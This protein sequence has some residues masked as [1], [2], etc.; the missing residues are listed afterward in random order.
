MVQSS[1]VLQKRPRKPEEQVAPGLTKMKKKS[2]RHAIPYGVAS[3]KFALKTECPVAESGP[4][5]SHLLEMIYSNDPVVA[6]DF[7]SH[8][9]SNV[10]H[11]GFDV[12][13]R[14]TYRPGQ[15]PNIALLQFAPLQHHKTS[16]PVLLYAMY[17][18]E[19]HIP[20]CLQAIIKD[21]GIQKYGIG[22]KGDIRHL[23]YMSLSE[24]A[25]AS[26]VELGPMALQA[27]VVSRK[28][29]GLK[30]LI[31]V[32]MGE[33]VAEYKTKSLTMTNWENS[34]LSI[35]QQKYASMDAY[36]A[37][38]IY[39]ILTDILANTSSPMTSSASTPLPS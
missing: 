23:Q 13:H 19:G 14:P 6:A 20:E 30:A 29:I 17:H 39:V 38:E 7:V 21:S 26:F 12:E 18:D 11:L 25:K 1:S 27:G 8:H 24:D 16:H 28:E 32:T 34:G 4:Y 36:A 22:I 35:A 37:M 15:K 9:M 3:Q 31:Q 2:E 5:H 33:E 10:K